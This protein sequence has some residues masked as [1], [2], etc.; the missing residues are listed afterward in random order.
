MII[1]YLLTPQGVRPIGHVLMVAIFLSSNFAMARESAER[2]IGRIS[3]PAII[4]CDRNQLTSWTGEVTAY[5][6][7][8]HTTLLEISTDEDTIEQVRIEHAG[9]VD[10]SA[11]YLLWGEPFTHTNWAAIE[12]AP[13]KL[14]NNMRV[15]A[16]ICLDGQTSPVVD[17]K[18]DE[19]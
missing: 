8:T 6:R 19:D 5:R 9:S 2:H 12:K 14:I 18:P 3:P 10:A 13:G 16:W 4:S 7:E 17:W 1:D 15:T 11:H